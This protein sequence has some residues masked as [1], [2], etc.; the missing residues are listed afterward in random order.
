MSQLRLTRTM[1]AQIAAIR[2]VLTPWGLGTAL[3]NE[4][5]H[6]V[7]KVFARDGGAHRLTI[8][9]T[10]KDRDAAINKARQ[11]AKRLLTHLNARA[12]F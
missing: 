6:L 12:G 9:C 11:N 3:V 2:D 8:S 7:V 1:R 4:G 5:P 10:P